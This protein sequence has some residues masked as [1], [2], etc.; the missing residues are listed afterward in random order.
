VRGMTL[1]ADRRWLALDLNRPDAAP[2]ALPRLD[3]L[4]Q[5]LVLGP[6]G[7]WVS[8][9]NANNNGLRFRLGDIQGFPLNQLLYYSFA[10]GQ[11]TPADANAGYYQLLPASTGRPLDRLVLARYEQPGPVTQLYLVSPDSATPLPI[12]HL[13]GTVYAADLS[14]DGHNLLCTVGT[15]EPASPRLDLV[16]L[17]LRDPEGSSQVIASLISLQGSGTLQGAFVPGA[18]P[19][20]ML[21]RRVVGGTTQLSVRGLVD[22]TTRNLW[23]GAQATGAPNTAF[24]DALW[25]SPDGRWVGF[26]PQAGQ[27][28]F[29]L[30]LLPLAVPGSAA[31]F[32][33]PGKRAGY[34]LP[35]FPPTTQGTAYQVYLGERVQTGAQNQ[36]PQLEVYSVAQAHPDQAPMLLLQRPPPSGSSLNLGV[37]ASG[38][39][40]YGTGTDLR[41]RPL[42]GGPDYLAVPGADM[43]WALQSTGMPK[44]M[45]PLNAGP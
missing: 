12:I 33:L 23:R 37:T 11:I 24:A 17:D 9:R 34:W 25:F 19:P 4:V 1:A 36:G 13:P 31:T 21:I 22:G 41:L 7:V 2:R 15:T 32:P 18:D 39:L 10:S 6:S 43:F 44:F 3:G 27:T 38:L 20:Q 30:V 40:V 16:L 29:Q 5:A 42:E 28:A 8:A 26:T 35:L 45:Q 14:A